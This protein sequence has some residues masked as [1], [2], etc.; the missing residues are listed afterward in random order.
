MKTRSVPKEYLGIP[1]FSYVNRKMAK[2]TFRTR[3]ST[4]SVPKEYLGIPFFSYANRKMAKE[5][6]FEENRY[7][8][9][10]NKK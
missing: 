7:L 1:F 3:S 6:F 10:F 5:T 8:D 9:L 2:E 4:R